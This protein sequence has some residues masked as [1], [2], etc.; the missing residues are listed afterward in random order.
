M[1]RG[2]LL[3]KSAGKFLDVLSRFN[4]GVKSSF[5]SRIDTRIKIA[6]V[7]LI[8]AMIAFL[9][10]NRQ[11][12]FAFVVS[13]SLYL[14]AG[15]AF[16]RV[17]PFVL[18]SLGFFAVIA[19]PTFALSGQLVVAR[20]F[21]RSFSSLLFVLLMTSTSSIQEMIAAIPMPSSL[22]LILTLTHMNIRKMLRFSRD[23]YLARISRSPAVLG[24]DSHRNYIGLF[25]ARL[26]R[27]SLKTSDEIHFALV[28]RGW[29]SNGR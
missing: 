2:K 9:Q 21:L 4:P 26:F 14:F 7:V 23:S 24:N 15:S 1:A 5:I 12:L 19:L 29:R 17:W 11:L 22:R 16:R 13:L 3:E 10:D 20:L 6:A 27:N 18:A 28:S 8:V 25:L